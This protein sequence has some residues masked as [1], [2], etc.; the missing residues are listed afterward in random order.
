[1][2]EGYRVPDVAAPY[3]IAPAGC[4]QN[5]RRPRKTWEVHA[6]W[7]SSDPSISSPKARRTRGNQCLAA[8]YVPHVLCRSKAAASLPLSCHL[9]PCR[10]LPCQSASLCCLPSDTR[11]QHADDSY[12]ILGLPPRS[13]SRSP[14][15]GYNKSSTS[16]TSLLPSKSSRPCPR[17]H[18]ALPL[19]TGCDSPSNTPHPTP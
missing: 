19:F 8:K 9:L 16:R 14:G 10:A 6:F 7:P 11:S 3:R 18:H 17:Y 5:P 4:A 13:D 12:I 2:A 1:M 15:G